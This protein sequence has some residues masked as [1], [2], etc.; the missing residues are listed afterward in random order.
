MRLASVKS[1]AHCETL[2]LITRRTPDRDRA[3]HG[4]LYHKGLEEH[5][6]LVDLAC[7]HLFR[8]L[9]ISLVHLILSAPSILISM[10][11]VVHV[12]SD[13]PWLDLQ[14]C[15]WRESSAWAPN[16]TG[17]FEHLVLRAALFPCAPCQRSGFS[18]LAFGVLSCSPPT[19]DASGDA[20]SQVGQRNKSKVGSSASES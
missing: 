12:L 10:S 4:P 9:Q 11:S 16:T 7:S 3:S 1:L 19:P 14:T 5:R 8:H 6:L 20:P 13:S 2:V 18:F 17:Q 15:A